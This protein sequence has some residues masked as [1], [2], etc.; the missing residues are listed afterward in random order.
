MIRLVE[1]N[2]DYHFYCIPYGTVEPKEV[3]VKCIFEDDDTAKKYLIFVPEENK[4]KYFIR[5]YIG[6]LSEEKFFKV[7][8]R[9]IV[10]QI[11]NILGLKE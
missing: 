9:N 1:K 6:R 8:D 11:S 4:Y 5:E 7:N 3:V 10:H 2:V